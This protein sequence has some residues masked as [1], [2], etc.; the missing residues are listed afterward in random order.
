MRAALALFITG[1]ILCS[2][3]VFS[4]STSGTWKVEI[5]LDLSTGLIEPSF[6]LTANWSTAPLD[7][8]LACSLCMD[9]LD[10]LL[11][12]G[13]TSMGDLDL[14]MAMEF[15]GTGSLFDGA[16]L[17]AD[18]SANASR[19]SLLFDLGGSSSSSY[20][21]LA[22][23][24]RLSF[25]QWSTELVLSGC[26]LRFK[27]VS[28]ELSD[29]TFCCVEDVEVEV[30]FDCGGFVG[31]SISFGDVALPMFEFITISGTIDFGLEEK[32]L[33]LKLGASFDASDN[34]IGVGLKLKT[35][36]ASIMGLEVSSL[37][38]RCDIGDVQVALVHTSA[39]DGVTLSGGES[40]ECAI[41]WMAQLYL[42][43][44]SNH[45][46]CVDSLAFTLTYSPCSALTF[47]VDSDISMDGDIDLE[48]SMRGT[49]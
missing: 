38:I 44:S 49:W 31:A 1:L 9:G 11:I 17:K 47:A 23:S 40:G 43:D 48:F 20:L 35:D 13:S 41:R 19:W 36:G 5:N 34:C 28:V 15:D 32:D 24:G 6:E 16:E 39:W 26:D 4:D 10:E 33:D 25:G 14:G 45:L 22:G 29:L 12:E 7:L 27:E 3:P 8:S 30:D 42:K 46:F 37:D 21:A 18:W 2:I